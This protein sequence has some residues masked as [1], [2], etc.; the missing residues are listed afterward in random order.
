MEDIMDDHEL[1]VATPNIEP[2][3]YVFKQ[4][5]RHIST[6][7]NRWYLVRWYEN[8]SKDDT[9]ETP[10]HLPLQDAPGLKNVIM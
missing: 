2:Q 6:K 9:V 8:L 5:I 3:E 4:I 1:T 10:E 7:A